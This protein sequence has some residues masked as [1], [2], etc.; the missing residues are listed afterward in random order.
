MQPEREVNLT[1]PPSTEVKNVCSYSYT[2][3]RLHGM[4][5]DSITLYLM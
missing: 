4:D 5:W 2:S 3:A 1:L